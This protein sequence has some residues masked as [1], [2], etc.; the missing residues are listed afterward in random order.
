MKIQSIKNQSSL[1]GNIAILTKDLK[2]HE[3]NMLQKNEKLLNE[4][5][6]NQPFDYIISRFSKDSLDIAIVDR[7]KRQKLPNFKEKLS[8]EVINYD[9]NC[10]KE[11]HNLNN[12]YETMRFLASK[13]EDKVP[14]QKLPFKEKITRFFTHNS[15]EAFRIYRH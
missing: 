6:K 3:I 1:K 4:F 5:A 12:I 2:K 8:T 14:Y 11:Q 10:Q 9:S 15:K 13:W 7:K